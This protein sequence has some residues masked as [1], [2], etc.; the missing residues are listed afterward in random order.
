MSGGMKQRVMGALAIAGALVG[1]PELIVLDEPVSA[2]DASIR[3]QIMNLFKNLQSQ[4]GVGYVLV[5][6]DLGT[7]RYTNPAAR[8]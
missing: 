2:L 4:F 5:A 7:T 8:P 1:R 3:S 6:H